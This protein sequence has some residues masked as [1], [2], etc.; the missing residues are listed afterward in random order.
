MK[1]TQEKAFAPITIVLET[2]RE[3]EV[4]KAIVGRICGD[5]FGPRKVAD[6]ILAHLDNLGIDSLPISDTAGLITLPDSFPDQ[7]R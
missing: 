6:L 2:R 3:A 1:V 4:L 7:S 5:A